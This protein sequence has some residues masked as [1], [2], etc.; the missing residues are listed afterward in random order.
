MRPGLHGLP[1]KHYGKLLATFV[2]GLRFARSFQGKDKRE[3]ESGAWSWSVGSELG[4]EACED[5]GDG[6]DGNSTEALWAGGPKGRKEQG[7]TGDQA[8]ELKGRGLQPVGTLAAGVIR[9]RPK[10]TAGAGME[11]RALRVRSQ[12]C[13]RL[14][15]QQVISLDAGVSQ[16]CGRT[17]RRKRKEK[18]EGGRKGP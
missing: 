18:G 16:D 9:E 17:W 2:D 3:R 8:G 12:G 13:E 15:L 11:E 5:S 14:G 10:S 4:R 6:G 7:V 1:A